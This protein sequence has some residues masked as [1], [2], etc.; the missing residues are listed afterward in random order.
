MSDETIIKYYKEGFTID[1][2]A[3]IYYRYKNRKLKPIFANGYFL[4]PSKLLNK[5]ECRLHVCEV[6]YHFLITGDLART[7][8]VSQ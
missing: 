7:K 3:D 4:Y 6:I 2:I 5:S 8:N 1:Y